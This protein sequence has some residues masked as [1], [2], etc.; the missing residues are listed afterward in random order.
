MQ[1][2]RLRNL[3]ADDQTLAAR[4][5][6]HC[7]CHFDYFGEFQFVEKKKMDDID[8]LF[9]VFTEEPNVQRPVI[10]T[11]RVEPKPDSR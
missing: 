2:C 3:V 10:G 5:G 11:G 9:S 6:A 1:R 7:T 8:D 4:G